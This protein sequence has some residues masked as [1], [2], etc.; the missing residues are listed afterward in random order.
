MTILN[1]MKKYITII[2]YCFTSYL[3]FGQSYIIEGTLYDAG[4]KETI[5]GVVVYF[6]GTSIHTTS[7]KDGYFRIATE[8]RINTILIF[9]HL[10][11]ESLIIENPFEYT[12]KTFYLK[13]KVNMLQAT[14][15]TTELMSREEMMHIFKEHLIGD[16]M[17]GASCVILNEED[18][19]LH[20]NSEKEQLQAFLVS[21]LVIENKYLGYHVTYDLHEFTIQY[22]ETPNGP[23]IPVHTTCIGTTSFVDTK[24]YDLKTTTRRNDAYVRSTAYFWKNLVEDNLKEAKFKIYQQN[25]QVEQG[26]YFTILSGESN[27]TVYLSSPSLKNRN[28]YGINKPVFGV[29]R[30]FFNNQHETEIVFLTGQLS[31]DE[32]G[33]I[34]P[35]DK[36]VYFGDMGNQ[37]IGEMLPIDFKYI[38]V[39]KRR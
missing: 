19:R 9:S 29:I 14:V 23:K 7:D 34:D 21:P 26:Q 12:E 24:P 35:I 30:V 39:S 22:N 8:T 38:P 31:V 10:L 1:E 27:S 17:A 36:V 5:P 15:V 4:T 11:Y 3:L 18:I 25:K 2:F 28:P 32:F 6:N 13:E 37:R 16:S 20:Y 33:N